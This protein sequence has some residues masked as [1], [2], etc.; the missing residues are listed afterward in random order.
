MMDNSFTEQL[1]LWIELPEAERNYSVGAL[2]L[3]KLSGN[4]IM[5]RN[6]VANID[7]RHEF[8]N[9][10][11]QKYYNFRVQSLTHDQVTQ[12]QLQ[13]DEIIQRDIPLAANADVETRLENRKGKR[14]DHDSL[15]QNIQDLF[16]QNL[17]ILQKMRELHLQLRNLSTTEATCPDSARYPFLKELIKLDKSLHENWKQ[18]DEFVA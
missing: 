4:P 7:K 15:P 18:Y 6:I 5:Y 13:V 14:A 10:E 11:L 8:I 3:L 1:R 17:S 12:M 16:T 2:Y 9:Y